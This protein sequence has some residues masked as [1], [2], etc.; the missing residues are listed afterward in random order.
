M[1]GPHPLVI[2]PRQQGGPVRAG[3]GFG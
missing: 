3:A 2:A 1:L